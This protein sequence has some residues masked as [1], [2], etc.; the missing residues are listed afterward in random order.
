MPEN[1][2]G[3]QWHR[4]D[5]ARDDNLDFLKR[6]R[7]MADRHGAL[8][9]GE[10]VCDDGIGLL[11]RYLEGGDKLHTGY[12]LELPSGAPTAGA[13]CATI[14]RI[15][16][17][18]GEQWPSFALSNHDVPRVVSRLMWSHPDA[19]SDCMPQMARAMLVL[20]LS[21]RGVCLLYQG[22]ELG[23][24]Q[25][26]LPAEALRDPFTI[27]FDL[28]VRGRDGARTPMPWSSAAP[29]GGFSTAATT[30]LPLPAAHLALAVDTQQ[31]GRDDTPLAVARKLIALRKAHA[32]LRRG[33]MTVSL[34][35]E[36]IMTIRRAHG[37]EA[38][39]SWI[40]IGPEPRQVSCVGTPLLL[41]GAR[42]DAGGL[43][44]EGWGAA[45]MQG[46][47]AGHG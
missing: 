32:A 36:R 41:S 43:V 21:L 12:V 47:G 19:E 2:Y 18:C 40:N 10:V 6:L 16:Q 20:L 34:A 3:L 26:E 13:L 8:L 39:T 9:L 7:A 14:G 42:H 28:G 4:Y 15:A 45:V 30:W 17:S 22:E 37:E 24:P 5:K 46:A 44:L 11:G 31:G 1:P 27:D 29:N 35:G 38:V 25:A 23:L 33:S